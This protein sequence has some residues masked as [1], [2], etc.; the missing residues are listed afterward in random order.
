[1]ELIKSQEL[2]MEWVALMMKAKMI[3]YTKEDVRKA[4]TVL[5]ESNRA[6]REETA[7]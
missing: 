5:K 3:G 1:M 2:D 4:L 6:D 7:V